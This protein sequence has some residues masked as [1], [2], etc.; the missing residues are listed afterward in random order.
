M[1]VEY[2]KIAMKE[3]ALFAIDSDAHRPQDVGNFERGIQI[4]LDAGLPSSRIVNAEK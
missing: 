4:A 1:T 2:V 3:G